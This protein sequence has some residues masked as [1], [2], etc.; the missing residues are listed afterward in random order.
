M[1]IRKI[2]LL[3]ILSFLLFSCQK[4]VN[5]SIENL[6]VITNSNAYIVKIDVV[7]GDVAGSYTDQITL[8]IKDTQLDIKSNDQ[9]LSTEL[10]SFQKSTLQNTLRKLVELHDE[11]KI[12]LKFGGC[13][14]RD[15]NYTI[16]NNAITMRVKP[17][18]GTVVYHEI[19]DIIGY[20]YNRP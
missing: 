14:A 13:T 2:S 19:L 18:S 16:E 10:N 8:E 15:Q 7:S 17:K 20:I 12:P 4:E 6:D 3:C 5:A 9:K 1:I 11:E